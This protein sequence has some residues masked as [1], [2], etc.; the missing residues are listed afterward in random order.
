[1]FPITQLCDHSCLFRKC[2]TLQLV[3]S[4]SRLTQHTC[5]SLSDQQVDDLEE[6]AKCIYEAQLVCRT[7]VAQ[8]KTCKVILS[9]LNESDTQQH[10]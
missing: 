2:R 9:L 10:R 4:A 6:M 7:A 5:R 1:M 3:R 8:V